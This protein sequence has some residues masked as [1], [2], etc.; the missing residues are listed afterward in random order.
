[1]HRQICRACL[2]PRVAFTLGLPYHE[3]MTTNQ[4]TS[5]DERWMQH[6]NNAAELLFGKVEGDTL[7]SD[8]DDTCIAAA[9]EAIRSD[10]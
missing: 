3:D 5:T 6:Y 2:H 4:P 1:M 10:G 9:D 7:T 8:E